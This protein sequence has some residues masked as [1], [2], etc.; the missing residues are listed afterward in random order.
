MFISDMSC[1]KMPKPLPNS[2]CK[3]SLK[4]TP[5]SFYKPELSLHHTLSASIFV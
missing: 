5:P 1:K 3:I 4:T 2:T